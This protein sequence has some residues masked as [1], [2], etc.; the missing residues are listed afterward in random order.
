MIKKKFKGICKRRTQR[1]MAC[2]QTNEKKI[3]HN[4]HLT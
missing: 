3:T 2:G 4:K 1:L